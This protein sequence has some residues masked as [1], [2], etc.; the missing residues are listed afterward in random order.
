MPTMDRRD[1]PTTEIKKSGDQNVTSETQTATFGTKI[2]FFSS[3]IRT[4]PSLS[5]EKRSSVTERSA[6]SSRSQIPGEK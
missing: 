1:A 3:L 6:L 4:N 2:P 5:P